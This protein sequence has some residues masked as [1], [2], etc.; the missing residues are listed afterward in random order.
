MEYIS[1]SQTDRYTQTVLGTSGVSYTRT[2]EADKRDANVKQFLAWVSCS[3]AAVSVVRN[4]YALR[5]Y[6]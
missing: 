4:L 5:R 6:G 3:R 2:A 1:G